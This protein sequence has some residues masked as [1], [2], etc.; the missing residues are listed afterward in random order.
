MGNGGSCCQ[1]REKEAITIQSTDFLEKF[2]E[3]KIQ[4]KL[5]NKQGKE[6]QEHSLKK[7]QFGTLRSN[8][9]KLS[10]EKISNSSF[11]AYKDAAIGP[12]NDLKNMSFSNI[13]FN[14]DHYAFHAPNINEDYDE[15]LNSKHEQME[16]NVMPDKDSLI[17]E[18]NQYIKLM[19]MSPKSAFGS[20]NITPVKNITLLKQQQQEVYNDVN[21]DSDRHSLIPQGKLSDPSKRFSARYNDNPRIKQTSVG[22]GSLVNDSFVSEMRKLNNQNDQSKSNIQLIQNQ[23]GAKNALNG[24]QSARVT[25]KE[26]SN[27]RSPKK[28]NV[29]VIKLDSVA[30]KEKYFRPSSSQLNENANNIK[31]SPMT[32]TI[33]LFNSNNNSR[34]VSSQSNMIA[35]RQNPSLNRI[36]YGNNLAQNKILGQTLHVHGKTQTIL[37][38]QTINNSRL[39][40]GPNYLEASYVSGVSHGNGQRRTMNY[41]NISMRS[42]QPPSQTSYIQNKKLDESQDEQ[43]PFQTKR[44]DLEDESMDSFKQEGQVNK[45]GQQKKNAQDN[46]SDEIDEIHE[47]DFDEQV[48]DSESEDDE[49]IQDE[50]NLD[51]ESADDQALPHAKSYLMMSNFQESPEYRTLKGSIVDTDMNKQ[52]QRVSTAFNYNATIQSYNSKNT[53][54]NNKNSFTPLSQSIAGN[55]QGGSTMNSLDLKKKIGTNIKKQAVAGNKSLSNKFQTGVKNAYGAQLLNSKKIINTNISSTLTSTKKKR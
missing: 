48:I 14:E 4:F 37:P 16:E 43:E 2:K 41:D 52:N 7:Q 23:F 24:Y 51:Y 19:D 28:I 5:I 25:Q 50:S 54:S 46:M 27:S 42:Y 13:D 40:T 22:G 26:K 38:R 49:V 6:E 8:N 39:M 34:P 9:L 3:S 53:N 44:K 33:D 29:S 36:S 31:S 55:I 15:A 32:I 18:Q 47:S 35:F 17:K 20:K 45:P 10:A 30:K 21:E 12:G 11:D 1:S